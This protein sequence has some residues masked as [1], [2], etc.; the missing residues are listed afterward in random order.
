MFL[1][2]C[3]CRC[4]YRFGLQVGLHVCLQVCVQMCAGGF[5]GVCSN[6][7]RCVY[8]CEGVLTAVC[9]QVFYCALQGCLPAQGSPHAQVVPVDQSE[10]ASTNTESPAASLSS[11]PVAGISSRTSGRFCGHWPGK[12]TQNTGGFY[13]L[14]WVRGESQI[15]TRPR[16]ATV[17]DL[18][19]NTNC[20]RKNIAHK[21]ANSGIYR[22]L[23]PMSYVYITADK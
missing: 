19:R 4:V 15:Y 16:E 11:L 5:K 20:R 9:L 6:V 22:K 3:V 1:Q 12:A 14:T 17:Q 23:E 8:R 21:Q 7:C 13:I 10:P 18:K 2:L